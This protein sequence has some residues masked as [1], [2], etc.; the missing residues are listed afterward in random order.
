MDATS[1]TAL[2]ES[3]LIASGYPR[4]MFKSNDGEMKLYQGKRTLIDLRMWTQRMSEPAVSVL[5]SE[6]ELTR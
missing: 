2:A 5:E 3:S 6:D 1:E 4:L